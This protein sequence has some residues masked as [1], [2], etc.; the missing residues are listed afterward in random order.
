MQPSTRVIRA[1]VDLAGEVVGINTLIVRSSQTGTVAEG[2]GFAIPINTAS[3]MA[4]QIIQNGYVAHPY[5]GISYQ[6]ISPDVAAAYN[7]PAQW[8]AY[9]TNVTSD[10]PASTAN[11]QTG[12]IITGINS[13]ALDESHTYLNTLFDYKPGDQ[14]TLDLIRNNQTMQVKVTLGTTTT[15]S[16]S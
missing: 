2:L 16:S 9:I 1:L 14:V 10:S 8:G 12:D 6:P 15:S 11:L 3:A 5:L 7:L 4:E 13:T